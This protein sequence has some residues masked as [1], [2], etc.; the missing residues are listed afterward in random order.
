ME[1][2]REGVELRRLRQ[3]WA[4]SAI[5]KVAGRRLAKEAGLKK[6]GDGLLKN[7]SYE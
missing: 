5:G 4:K 7:N 2:E 1:I 6:Q 3:R